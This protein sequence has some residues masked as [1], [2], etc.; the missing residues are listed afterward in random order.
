MN[1][2]SWIIVISI[3]VL[4]YTLAHTATKS[5]RIDK[6]DL[7]SKLTEAKTLEQLDKV[8]EEAYLERSKRISDLGRMLHSNINDDLKARVCFLLGEFR[9]ERAMGDL[10]SIMTFEHS[11]LEDGAMEITNIPRWFKYPA[12]EALAKCGFRSIPQM[13]KKLETSDDEEFRKFL[14]NAIWTNIGTMLP[15]A[16]DGKKYARQ[17]I[18]D[19]I[20]IQTDPKKKAKLQDTL[21][22][23]N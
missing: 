19:Y 4:S 13:V 18:E 20:V 15:R 23:L 10:G 22:Y 3:V 6:M 1:K 8:V 16:T 14:V 7:R 17:I 12:T 5:Q 2:N 9:A 21:D 11:D